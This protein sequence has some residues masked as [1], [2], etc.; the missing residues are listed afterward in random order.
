[1]KKNPMLTLAIFA[2]AAGLLYYWLRRKATAAQN[3]IIEP[4]NVF[5]NLQKTKAALYT[6]IYYSVILNLINN[7]PA[8]I[9]VRQVNLNVMLNGRNFGRIIK[10]APFKVPRRSRVQEK[11][12]TSFS[13][14]G[15]WS[16]I[17]GIIADGLDFTFD[18]EGFINTD[19]GR[20]DIKFR[21]NYA[22]DFDFDKAGKFQDDRVNVNA[23]NLIDFS[24]DYNQKKNF[25]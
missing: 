4:N 7:E 21:K 24:T 6:Q 11:F 20:V 5:I 16:L 1:M 13:S 12:E 17:P 18:V 8:D 15:I 23:P 19:L 10:N 25:I 22:Y 14:L 3:I 2:G 9:N